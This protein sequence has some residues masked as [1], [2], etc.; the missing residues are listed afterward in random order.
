LRGDRERESLGKFFAHNLI[1]NGGIAFSSEE[2]RASAKKHA[3]DFRCLKRLWRENAQ[4][5]A[6]TASYLR[7]SIGSESAASRQ[8]G[9]L[10]LSTTA[11]F[12]QPR[13]APEERSGAQFLSDEKQI[14]ELLALGAWSV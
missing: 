2:S 4:F 9:C 5:T 3:R 12:I 8:S 7:P 1:E 6:V 10:Y 11:V 13:Y 14:G